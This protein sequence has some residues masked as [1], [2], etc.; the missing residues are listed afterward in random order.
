M[1][2]QGNLILCEGSG[3]DEFYP[4]PLVQAPIPRKS[5]SNEFLPGLDADSEAENPKLFNRIMMSEQP[6][7][8]DFFLGNDS[9]FFESGTAV[10]DDMISQTQFL[11]SDM[12]LSQQR[13]AS[14]PLLGHS[15]SLNSTIVGN[16]CNKAFDD[17]S[18][19]LRTQYSTP[20]LMWGEGD[21]NDQDVLDLPLTS[22]TDNK[23]ASDG[24]QSEFTVGESEER[25]QLPSMT[26]S[27]IS[28]SDAYIFSLTDIPLNMIVG[29][30]EFNLSL[31]NLKDIVHVANG[32]KSNIFTARLRGVEV[33][34]KM[35]KEEL[36]SD[37]NAMVEF[38]L[39]SEILRRISHPN[40]VQILGAGTV[41]RRFLV[42][43][44]LQAGTLGNILKRRA[45]E[46]KSTPKL[47]RRPFFT[48]REVLLKAQELASALEYLHDHVF[49]GACIIH[50]GDILAIF[51]S[52]LFRVCDS[53][54]HK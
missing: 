41:P 49:E 9:V 5:R 3:N 43:E 45:D 36:Q 16:H 54:H 38:A 42:S 10:D 15:Y 19:T 21:G 17:D 46:M 2:F 26:S 13:S 27:C 50:R 23:V 8:T 51:P 44:N 39:E 6:S 40:I 47:F 22:V 34:V 52:F 24:C 30:Q 33:V 37:K 7:G 28:N 31:G 25:L 4:Q 14:A 18:I 53:A 11:P 20:D 35:I 1:S 32:S 48:F 12:R 29:T